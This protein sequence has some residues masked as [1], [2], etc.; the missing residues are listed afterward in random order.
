VTHGRNVNGEAARPQVAGARPP[1]YPPFVSKAFTSE[2]T[3]DQPVL[4]REGPRLAPGEVR[5]V[6][7]EGHAA[8]A[9]EL[10][11]LRAERASLGAA[12][13]T[14]RAL[15][16]AELSR[17]TAL[18]EATLQA[19]TIQP[20]PDA[21]DGEVA[22]GRWV[23]VEEESGARVTWRLVGPDEADPR[24]GL[25]S[26]RAP[27]ARALLGRREGDSVEVQRP[28]GAAE[29]TVVAVRSAP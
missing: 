16:E 17:R 13:P 14:E 22:F 3:A 10:E 6:T 20:P 19:V 28:G 8:L 29:L 27:V 5:P 23:T 25:L 4:G 12:G 18:V 15:R 9:A 1:R 11:R 7:A 21:P 24:R 2:E 26:V